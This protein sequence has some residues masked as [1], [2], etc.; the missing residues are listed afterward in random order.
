M[1]GRLAECLTSRHEAH[2]LLD[3]QGLGGQSCTPRCPNPKPTRRPSER[4][5]RRTPRLAERQVARAWASPQPDVP[6]SH[7]DRKQPT[8]SERRAIGESV[9]PMS[10]S[11]MPCGSSGTTGW[12]TPAEN[13]ADTVHR[14]MSVDRTVRPI[15]AHAGCQQL[16]PASS[17]C[18]SD[19]ERRDLGP[20]VT[21]TGPRPAA[22]DAGGAPYEIPMSWPSWPVNRDGGCWLGGLP[23]RR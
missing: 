15:P 16:L 19:G 3:C 21:A 18:S 12:A 23:R 20:D 5:P 2:R 14:E 11:R 8:R 22:V 7:S 10:V 13:G 4:R 9:V 6:R 1:R 17:Q